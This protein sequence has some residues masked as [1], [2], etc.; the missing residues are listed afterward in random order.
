VIAVFS[1]EKKILY[2][3]YQ[4]P[5]Q[6]TLPND[7]DMFKNFAQTKNFLISSQQFPLRKKV[8]N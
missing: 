4:L 2:N 6:F 1:N 5:Q 8:Q 7:F 3:C